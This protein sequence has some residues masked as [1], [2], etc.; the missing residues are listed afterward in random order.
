MTPRLS[1][2]R[3]WIAGLD[4]I[5]MVCL[6]HVFAQEPQPQSGPATIAHKWRHRHPADSQGRRSRNHAAR[7]SFSPGTG[8]NTG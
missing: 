6:G 7:E 8:R 3:V 2:F 1:F 5:T 4:L